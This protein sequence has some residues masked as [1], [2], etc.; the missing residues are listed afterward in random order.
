MDEGLLDK[1]SLDIEIRF[2]LPRARLN[3]EHTNDE[4]VEQIMQANLNMWRTELD[5]GMQIHLASVSEGIILE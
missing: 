4:I 3:P 2:V 5:D 1:G